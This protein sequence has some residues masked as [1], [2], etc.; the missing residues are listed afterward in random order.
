M[1]APTRNPCWGIVLTIVLMSSLA[2][3]QAADSMRV[4]KSPSRAVLYSMLLPGAG[5]VYNGKYLKAV[6][7]VAAQA[8]MAYQFSR[9]L[10]IYNEWEEELYDLPRHRYREKRNK[11][12]WWTAFV[13]IYNILDALV[14]SHLSSFHVDEFEG[15]EPVPHDV[16]TA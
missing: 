6:F 14:D 3:G 5:Q 4:E 1:T 16:G 7:V 13:Y 12:A 2:S 10:E 8:Y 11:F 15:T 9:N